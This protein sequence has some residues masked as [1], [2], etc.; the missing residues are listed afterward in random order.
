MHEFHITA[1]NTALI[2]IYH[3]HETDCTS[4]GLGVSCWINDSLF[5]E[6][7]IET[8]DLI[9][10]WQASDH[11]RMSDTFKRPSGSDGQTEEDAFDFFHINS[12]DKDPLGNYYISSRHMHAVMCISP[13]GE[14]IWHLGGKNNNFTDLSNGEATNFSWQHHANWHANN[15]LSIFDNHGDHIL[16]NRA[17]FS[18]GMKVSLNLDEMTATLI[19]AYVHPNEI[20]ATSQGSVQILPGS[21]NAFVG[22]G[23]SPVYTEFS[24]DGEVLCDA[25]FGPAVIFEILNVGL[26][27]SYR[28]FRSHWVG[29]P[30]A[31]PAIKVKN[32]KAYV[33]WNG[34]TEVKS[35]RLQSASE[36]GAAD[37]EFVTIQE[38]ERDGFES[39]FELEGVSEANV[40]I[41]ALDGKRSVMSYTEVVSAS[42]SDSVSVLE[43]SPSELLLI[44][45]PVQV[46]LWQIMF[47]ICGFAGFGYLCWRYRGVISR[48]TALRKSSRF[49]AFRSWKRD[50]QSYELLE[51]QE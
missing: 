45:F 22:F 28:A 16:H 44:I 25:H 31:P 35:W 42:S 49:F 1:N 39:S 8:G 43:D 21:G 2:T 18:R 47:F 37:E 6:I 19:T 27:T 15:T 34:A 14:T 4:L 13:S 17:E 3:N 5:Q 30:K 26:V 46:S 11:V 24:P 9:F 32:G 48:S 40:R 51:A 38:L 36:V 20:L 10:Q 23:N 33:S 29:M 12:V 50:R 7:D 41:A